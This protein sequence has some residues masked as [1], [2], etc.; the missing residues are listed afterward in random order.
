MGRWPDS[1]YKQFLHMMVRKCFGFHLSLK[2]HETQ[3]GSNCKCT[4]DDKCLNLKHD[5]FIAFGTAMKPAQKHSHSGINSM[6]ATLDMPP[7]SNPVLAR[8]KSAFPE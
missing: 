7:H 5:L 4:E 8:L 2:L 1:A 6:C 3:I